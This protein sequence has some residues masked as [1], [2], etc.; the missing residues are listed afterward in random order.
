M[1]NV[2]LTWPLQTTTGWG[3]YALQLVLQSALRAANGQ[4]GTVIPC[5]GFGRTE[6]HPLIGRWLQPASV[7]GEPIAQQL[8]QGA[9][10]TT[11][12]VN[13][14]LLRALSADVRPSPERVKLIGT[15]EI[16]I[17]FFEHPIVSAAGRER[18]KAYRHIVTG[19]HWNEHRLRLAG[20]DNGVTIL[21]GIDPAT[22]HPAPR[23]GL[24]PGR[25]VIFSG[26]KLEFRK[27]QDIVLAAF[28]IFAR[29]HPDALLLTQWHSHWPEHAR[30]IEM[31]P[32]CQGPLPMREGQVDLTAWVASYG[33]PPHQHLDVGIV[34]NMRMGHLMREADVALFPNRCEGGTNLVAM[35][36]MACGIPCILSNN[37]GHLDLCD[38]ARNFV[39]NQ[40]R[41]VRPNPAAPA[42]EDW[43]ESSLQEVLAALEAAYTQAEASR[44]LGI[45]GA[46]WM[47]KL[48]WRTQ[49]GEILNL[50]FP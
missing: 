50:V 9:E 23:L 29:Q 34:D 46:N 41:V 30:G 7:L 37:T 45:C 43:G 17:T 32:H 20:I 47:A 31:A 40:Q 12:R 8:A 39:L 22:F 15:E 3:N 5:A 2:G 33:I 24:F 38:I 26:G 13:M 44:L 48:S 42:T 6:V 49:V 16:G 4:P 11:L 14:P 35:E 25:F 27:G 10:G 36:C 19:S 21:Q 1:Q 28:A 18:S